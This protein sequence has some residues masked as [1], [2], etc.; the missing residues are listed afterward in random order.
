MQD[1]YREQIDLRPGATYFEGQVQQARLE[2]DVIEV[3]GAAARGIRPWVT[4][5]GPIFFTEGNAELLHA[6]DA[7]PSRPVSS[8]PSSIWTARDNWEEFNAALARFAGPAQNFVYADVDGNIGYH[9][10]GQLPMRQELRGRRPGRTARAAMCEWEGLIP[11]DQLPHVFNPPSGMI[12]TA[13]QNP[14]PADYPWPVD[15][16]FS[17]RYRAQEIRALLESRASGA[18]GHADR[19]EGCLLGV[20]RFL[21][22]ASV[23]AWDKTNPAQMSRPVTR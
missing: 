1:L 16:R 4:R 21:R 12:V 19:A 5:H 10:T 3:K 15:G 17:S 11:Y 14:F 20:L 22:P 13:N 6:L 8:F 18:R 23:A 7:R 2:R 9:A